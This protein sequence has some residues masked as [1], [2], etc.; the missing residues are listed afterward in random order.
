MSADLLLFLVSL[1]FAAVAAGLEAGLYSAE[2]VRIDPLARDGDGR[3]RRLLEHVARPDRTLT[4]LLLANNVAHALCAR[5]A[6]PLVLP[7]AERW[8]PGQEAV[9]TALVLT[10]V[11]FIFAE[12]VPKDVF[13]RRPTPFLAAFEPVLTLIDLIFL[14]L[15]IPFAAMVRKLAKKDDRKTRILLD[16][17]DIET[18]LTSPVD[19]APLNESQQGLASAVLR[20]RNIVVRARM[21]PNAD[22]AT[23]S[24]DAG[25]DEVVAASVAS[26]K[27]RLAV[28]SPDGAGYL[29]YVAAGDARRALGRPWTARSALYTCPGVNAE[30]SIASALA[31]LQREG[32][33][34]GFVVDPASG[35]VLGLISAADIVSTLLDERPKSKTGVRTTAG[36]VA[37]KSPKG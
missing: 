33:P 30:L 23:V 32:R 36:T 17:T 3:Y 27:T 25:P 11:L 35:A 22:V 10:P 16:R 9:V 18:L 8:W 31:K 28:R 19:G 21:V 15:S 4:A 12:V 26:G 34:L 29:G 6:D 13:R 2:R 7:L 24:A 20:L 1:V 5:F 37:E 14:P